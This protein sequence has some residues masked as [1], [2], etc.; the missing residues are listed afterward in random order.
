MKYTQKNKVGQGESLPERGLMVLL[1]SFLAMPLSLSA[2]ELFMVE[3]PL[4]GRFV[5]EQKGCVN[6][7]AIKGDG[8][9]IGPDLAQKHFYGSFLQLAGI[10][11]NHAPEMLR[12][13]QELDLSYPE[14]S[15]TEMVELIAYLYYLRYLGEPGDLYR[16]KILVKEKSCLVCHSIA[17]KGGDLAP[18]FDKLAKYISPLYMA[19]ALWNHGPEMEKKI[20]KMGL[21]R[22]RFERGEIVD[23]SA[24]I[25]EASQGTERERVYM[26]PGNPNRGQ[27]VFKNKSCLDC[28]A[29]HGEGQD[30]GTDLGDLEWDYSVTEIA[31]V[32][33]NH[34]SEMAS[35]MEE[36]QI[37]WPRFGGKE[38]ADLIAYLYFLKF[39]D[40]PGD[41]EL[42]RAVFAE[43][44]C[45]NCHGSDAKGG[46]FAPDLSRSRGVASPIDM[47]QI[48]WNHA[49]VMEARITE[50]VMRWP[51]FS[52]DEMRNMYAFL[53]A[54]LRTNNSQL[55]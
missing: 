28:H 16:G 41:S 29:L 55:N 32:M 24:Y 53:H 13:M 14:F 34:G 40:K 11:L 39:R 48:M 43:K 33:W 49:P 23:L 10:M 36:Q 25:R 46:D 45:V 44:G 54:L 26:S 19:Q 31:G 52:G 6:C 47:A 37:N 38:M 1:C 27:Q 30:I 35:I 9:D 2:Q 5:F 3:N 50:K 8:G 4:K 20:L 17:G 42:G 51:Q 22:P 15:R 12:R 7:H 18:A 21:Q